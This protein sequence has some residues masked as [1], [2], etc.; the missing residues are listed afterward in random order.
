M[1]LRTAVERESIVAEAP[2]QI[3]LPTAWVGAEDVPVQ[4]SNAFVGVV[5]PNEVFLNIGSFVPPDRGCHGRGARGATASDRLHPDKAD[6]AYRADS[7]SA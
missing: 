7:G 4:F 2:K 5:A 3:E 6:R 1:T